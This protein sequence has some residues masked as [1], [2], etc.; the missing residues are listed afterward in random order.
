MEELKYL[1]EIL[2]FIKNSHNSEATLNEI[3]EKMTGHSYDSSIPENKTDGQV[4]INGDLE[5]NKTFYERQNKVVEALR[6]LFDERLLR[7]LDNSSTY[8]IT[9]AGITKS[10]FGFHDEYLEKEASKNMLHSNL[11]ATTSLAV[12]KKRGLKWTII[13]SWIAIILSIL[14]TVAALLQGCNDYFEDNNKSN[15]SR[16]QTE[17]KE[18]PRV[19]LPSELQK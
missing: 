5:I 17:E 14:A 10:N 19:K 1:D 16:I 9:F 12:A 18:L 8:R 3:C 7:S 2:R 11:E 13:R 15:Q 4:T 6:Y